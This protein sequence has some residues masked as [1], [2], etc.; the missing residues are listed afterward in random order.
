MQICPPWAPDRYEEIG[1]RIVRNSWGNITI[2]M[3]TEPNTHVH[4]NHYTMVATIRQRRKANEKKEPEINFKSVDVG[5]DTDE[6]GNI[7]PIIVKFNERVHEIHTNSETFN[8]VGIFTE[9]IKKTAIETLNIKPSKRKKTRLRP[10]NGNANCK[11]FTS[12]FATQR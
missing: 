6:Q 11:T 10:R 3:Q 12:D 4:T 8:D 1:H 7:N 9:A 2:N 5:P